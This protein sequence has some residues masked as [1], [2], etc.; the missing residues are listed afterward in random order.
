MWN[1]PRLLDAAAN[2]LYVLAGLLVAWAAVQALV[3][4]PAFALRLIEVHGKLEHVHRVQIVD[5]L[6]GRLRGTFFTADLDAIR[7]LFESIPWVY[8]AEVRR[9]W[10]DRLVVNLEEQ[11]AVAR[12]GRREDALLVNVHGELFK[13]ASEVDLPLFAGPSGSEREVARRYVEF[14][15]LLAPLG[16]EPREVLLSERFAWQVRIANGPTLQLGRDL[17]KDP[18]RERLARFAQA[19]PRTLGRLSRRLEYV[20]LR[21]P[22]GFALRI[23]GLQREEAPKGA[24]PANRT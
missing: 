7:G 24:R 15:A 12:W 13:A 6:Q 21:Y 8:R 16:F 22:D 17:A 11:F 18:V 10:P 4:S 3:R 5:A 23:P 20:D 19:Y 14:R 9:L 2:A 1:N